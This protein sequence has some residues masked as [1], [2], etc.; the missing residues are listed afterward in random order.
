M[1]EMEGK[2]QKD[3]LFDQKS[4]QVLQQKS[5]KQT[6]VLHQSCTTESSQ[7]EWSRLVTMDR[8]IRYN[9]G[10]VLSDIM[11]KELKTIALSIKLSQKQQ[12]VLSDVNELGV[13]Y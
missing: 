1:S 9:F 2:N 5:N 11:W 8:C 10:G 12:P 3:H 4:S 6:N 7:E 13:T